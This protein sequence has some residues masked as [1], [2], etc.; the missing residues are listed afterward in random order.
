MGESQNPIREGMRTIL[1]FATEQVE[2][3]QIASVRMGI[4]KMSRISGTPGMLR[5]EDLKKSFKMENESVT[6]KINTLGQI[7]ENPQTTQK[8]ASL[9][10]GRKNSTEKLPWLRLPEK[11]IAIGESW[12]DNSPIPVPGVAKPIILH[13]TYTLAEVTEKAGIRIARIESQSSIQEKDVKV[14]PSGMGQN[15]GNIKI[16]FSFR[17]YSSTG[18]GAI[19]FDLSHGIIVSLQDTATMKLDIAGDTSVNDA[20]FPTKYIQ[21][22]KVITHGRCA[23]QIPEDTKPKAEK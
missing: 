3:N 9:L 2:N 23:D 20:S 15:M 22:F 10:M 1:S 13:T 11:A 16:S 19:E 4:E 6:V 8:T 18:K 5:E 12:N 17:E 21:E 7:I 14:D